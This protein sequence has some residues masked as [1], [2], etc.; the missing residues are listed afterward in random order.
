MNDPQLPEWAEKPL[1]DGPI[2]L[3]VFQTRVGGG[4]TASGILVGAA[5]SGAGAAVIRPDQF[6][7]FLS[8]HRD[9]VLVCHDAASLHWRI[10]QATIGDGDAQETLWAYSREARLID[11][12]LL[13]QQIRN[14]EMRPIGRGNTLKRLAQ[15]L[16]EREL[17]TQDAVQEMVDAAMHGG[18]EKTAILLRSLDQLADATLKLHAVLESKATEIRSRID[19][20]FVGPPAA[21]TMTPDQEE[22][23]QSIRDLAFNGKKLKTLAPLVEQPFGILGVGIDVQAAIA[24]QRPSRPSLR[25][26]S[27]HRPG[28][29]EHCKSRFQSACRQLKDDAAAKPC[30]QWQPNAPPTVKRENGRPCIHANELKNWLLSFSTRLCDLHGMSATLPKTRDGQPSFDPEQWGMWADCDRGLSAWRKLNQLIELDSVV[31][32]DNEACVRFDVYPVIGSHGPNLEAVKDINAP[33]FR[34]H[35]GNSF[36]VVSLSD[37]KIRSFAKVCLGH[38]LGHVARLANHYFSGPFESI[39]E[40]VEPINEIAAD[41]YRSAG[42]ELL[43]AQ[44]HEFAASASTS[45]A[46]RRGL[47]MR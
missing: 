27:E 38:G 16:L 29:Q 18:P 26:D 10:H 14:Y 4:G 44:D 23:F 42:G 9:A 8:D 34:P 40:N 19:R 39:E 37:L 6:A 36:V 22:Q 13:D 28:F 11:I 31:A 1:G 3:V 30:F 33:I 20:A 46:G 2:A 21:V 45:G 32:S 47:T 25:I 15:K 12:G 35:D 41:L 7:T 43:S 17:P 5:R 24:L